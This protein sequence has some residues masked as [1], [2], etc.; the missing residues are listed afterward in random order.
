MMFHCFM[1]NTKT[2]S[3]SLE[4]TD[5][6]AAKTLQSCVCH[7]QN[8]IPWDSFTTSKHLTRRCL[9][10]QQNATFSRIFWPT[11]SRVPRERQVALPN[12]QLK[13][14]RGG[15][16]WLQICTE[17]DLVTTTMLLFLL[18]RQYLPLGGMFGLSRGAKKNLP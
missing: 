12:L 10:S 2:S 13:Q 8:K 5:T 1:L 9:A 18:V 4:R 3:T 14:Q 11:S 6:L 17:K 15:N 16:R 7:L